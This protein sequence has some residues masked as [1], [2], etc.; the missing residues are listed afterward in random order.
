MID[1]LGRYDRLC[2]KDQSLFLHIACFFNDENV[3]H[4][5]TMLA[6]TTLDVGNGL[7][8]LADRSLVHILPRGQI[9]MHYLLQQ[10]GR[11]IVTG[12]SNEP[13]KRQFLVEAEEIRDVLE[14]ETVSC[15]IYIIHSIEIACS[16]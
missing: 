2:D 14:N 11:Q 4:V 13:G 3:G 10:L 15:Y 9:V 8:I 16:L 7:K 12:Q 6:D 5:T 1:K